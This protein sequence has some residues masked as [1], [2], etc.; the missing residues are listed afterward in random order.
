M[1]RIVIT[2]GPGAGKTVITGEIARRHPEKFVAVAEAATQVYQSLKTRWDKL[3]LFGRYDAQRRMY[4]LQLEQEERTAREHPEK[5]L[6]LDRGTI[7]GAAYWPDGAA[8]FWRDVGTTHERELARY[9]AVMILETCAA[10][11]LYD[12]D[13]SN[14]VRFESSAAAMEAQ[15]RII[16]LWGEH[17]RVLHVSACQKM[18]DKIAAVEK[19]LAEMVS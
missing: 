8:A 19:V 16:E 4:R 13:A 11:G 7:D 9:D 3:D 6:L 1:R 10:I 5:T 12:N 17:P 2:G 15:R 14:P 18:E